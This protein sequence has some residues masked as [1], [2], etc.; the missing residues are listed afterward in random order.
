MRLA[1]DGAQHVLRLAVFRAGVGGAGGLLGAAPAE[2][3]G[4][5]EAEAGEEIVDG[6][7]EEGVAVELVGGDFQVTQEMGGATAVGGEDGFG[8]GHS[9]DASEAFELLFVGVENES[10]ADA[11]GHQSGGPLADVRVEE[12][13]ETLGGSVEAQAEVGVGIGVADVEP[14]IGETGGHGIFGE[15][16]ERAGD[17]G[18]LE[19]A[20]AVEFQEEPLAAGRMQAGV[21]GSFAHGLRRGAWCGAALPAGPQTTARGR[22]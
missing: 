13:G 17:E 12:G 4:L 6:E 7:G 5:V 11:I 1:D 19:I 10:Q 15:G 18:V 21:R 2:A 3:L 9:G 20:R 22:L 8:G 14:R 16:V